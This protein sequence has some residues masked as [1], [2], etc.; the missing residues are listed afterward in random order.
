MWELQFS[1]G[2]PRGQADPRCSPPHGS[3]T[4]ECANAARAE[5]ALGIGLGR[6]RCARHCEGGRMSRA[7]AG[8]PDRALLRCRAVFLAF[9]RSR[10]F[11]RSLGLRTARLRLR[12]RVL[13][14]A[15]RETQ[16]GNVVPSN[17]EV[18]IAGC[19]HPSR[20]L[21]DRHHRHVPL[22]RA[23]LGVTSFSSTATSELS[24]AHWLSRSHDA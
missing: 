9:S 18:P 4:L 23:S 12:L 6:V 5:H 21:E 16:F 19:Q 8:Q 14:L 2:R 7:A 13:G 20:Q 11:C 24:P 3:W 17:P 1:T 10:R 22:R 15:M